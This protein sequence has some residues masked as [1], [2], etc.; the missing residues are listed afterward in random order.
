MNSR[1]LYSFQKDNNLLKIKNIITK[2]GADE[3]ILFGSRAKHS[4]NKF[5]DYD[6]LTVFDR[7]L[8]QKEKISI[9][10][11]I[12]K[13]LAKY[14]IDIDIMVK[15]RKDIEKAKYQIGNTIKYAMADGV[16]I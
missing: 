10:T 16:V 14:L 1:N 3:I 4:E 12:R 11:R 15:T 5:S 9:E 13:E 7:S 2:Y 6:I 8:N